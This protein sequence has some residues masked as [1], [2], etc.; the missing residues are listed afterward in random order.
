[1]LRF[2]IHTS[3]IMLWL[4]GLDVSGTVGHQVAGAGV[5]ADLFTELLVVARCSITPRD[6]GAV[7]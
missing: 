1:M 4:E 2:H 6:D 3:M 5:L 7:L